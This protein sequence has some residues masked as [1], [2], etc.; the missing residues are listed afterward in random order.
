[1]FDPMNLVS[2]RLNRLRDEMD[3]LLGQAFGGSG[4]EFPPINL[5]EDD[6]RYYAEAELPGFKID[7]LELSVVGNTLSIKGERR[8]ETPEGGVWHRRERMSGAFERTVE[9]AGPIETARVEA[10]MANGVL[11]VTLPKAEALK[12]RKIQVKRSDA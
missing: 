2:N 1:M 3:Q 6:E 12:P 7:N 10:V 8:V 4:R 9:F 5:W 11:T